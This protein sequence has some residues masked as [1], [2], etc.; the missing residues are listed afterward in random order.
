MLLGALLVLGA[1]PDASAVDRDAQRRALALWQQ[2]CKSAGEFIRQTVADVDG[3]VLLKVR[4]AN[5]FG[6]QFALDDPY[7]AD[8]TGERYILNFL[9]GFHDAASG[10]IG[11]RYVEAPSGTARYR[12]TGRLEEPWQTDKR[13]LQG[14]VRFVADKTEIAQFSARY[15]VTFDDI[16]TREERE[17][18][19]AGSSLKVI[20]LRTGAVMAERVGYMV[21]LKQG[22]RAGGRSPWLLAADHACPDFRRNSAAAGNMPAAAAQAGQTL[23]FV[24]KVLRPTRPWPSR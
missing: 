4:R 3:I 5:N 15:G 1:S 18:W 19:I 12:Y 8:S 24:Q 9:Q 14:Y 16:S 21:D 10:R 2:R 22:E 17:L 13:Y 11:Y 23:D 6:D 7:G 20:D